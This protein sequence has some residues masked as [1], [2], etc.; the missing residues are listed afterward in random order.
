MCMIDKDEE[1]MLVGHDGPNVF[2][3]HLKKR[4]INIRI[5][6]VALFFIIIF[7]FHL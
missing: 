5:L 1:Q 3:S 4:Q 6:R 2:S 7:I